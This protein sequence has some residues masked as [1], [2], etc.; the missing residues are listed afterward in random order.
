M[1]LGERK[2]RWQRMFDYISAHNVSTWRESFLAALNA[3]PT[4]ASAQAAAQPD[5]A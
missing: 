1:P 3:C 5:P 4:A 2:R